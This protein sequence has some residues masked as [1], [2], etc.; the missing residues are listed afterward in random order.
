MGSLRKKEE[1]REKR[2]EKKTLGLYFPLVIYS[3]EKS[4][5]MEPPDDPREGLRKTMEMLRENPEVLEMAKADPEFRMMM[6]QAPG[7]LGM[8]ENAAGQS[9]G[10]SSKEE[11]SPEETRKKYP[12]QAAAAKGN[13]LELKYE[14][15]HGMVKSVL[16]IQAN[17]TGNGMGQQ[18][19]GHEENGMA[20][21]FDINQKDQKTGC[22]ALHLAS[23]FGHL[24]ACQLL[25]E[26]GADVNLKSKDGFTP[27][28]FARSRKN[29]QVERFLTSRGGTFTTTPFHEA[30]LHG[31]LTKVKRE[32]LAAM[33]KS[34]LRIQSGLLLTRGRDSRDISF[35]D[36][37]AREEKLGRS[38]LMHAT[39]EKYLEICR[40]LLQ[41]GASVNFKD[42]EGNTALMQS[43]Q[44]GHLGVC[45]LLLKSG[46]S[47]KLKDNEGFT[48]L[49]SSA[50]EGHLDVC[51]L[52]SQR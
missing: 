47:V 11:L 6:D 7:L 39:Q 48:A 2:E 13:V 20:T 15:L 18:G 44:E 49:I 23:T 4:V 19:H 5:R 36:I 41:C 34:I 27:A 26:N 31:D 21:F 12:V 46:A 42:N 35:F 43:A 37:D 3:G 38:G 29:H 14:I 17:L 45:H 8:L 33:F 50:Q 51:R 40:F 28:D 24:E 30:C 52:L 16:N 10:E 22:S 32:M 9:S 25:V 1:R